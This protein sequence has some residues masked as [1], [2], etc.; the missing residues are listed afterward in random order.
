MLSPDSSINACLVSDRFAA[1]VAAVVQLLDPASCISVY[2]ARTYAHGGTAV[3]CDASTVHGWGVHVGPFY[4]HGK[5]SEATLRAASRNQQR[6]SGELSISPLEL[7]TIAFLVLLVGEIPGGEEMLT[8]SRC[9][10]GR[11]DSDSSCCV[12]NSNRVHSPH[13]SAAFDAVIEA[14]FITTLQ[15]KLQHLDRDSNEIS[16]DLSKGRVDSACERMQDRF[17]TPRFIQ[18]PPALVAK[19]ERRVR[20]ADRS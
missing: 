5:W 18:L 7:L 19:W 2:D 8:A 14:G 10:V 6:G 4:S 17:G 12:V 3:C 15:V 1:D 9:F 13:M 16:D 20:D 11:S